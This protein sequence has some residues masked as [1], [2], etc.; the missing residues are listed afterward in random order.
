MN[1]DVRAGAFSIEVKV[2]DV[3]IA[4]SSLDAFAVSRI[5]SAGQ[6]IDRV[7]GYRQGLVEILRFDAGEH[8]TEDLLLRDSRFRI[9]IGDDRRIDEIAFAG[10]LVFAVSHDEAPFLL[11]DLDILIHLL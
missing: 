9:D 7:I 1:V 3:E 11:P 2:A 6:P 4:F 5:E 8:R 10:E